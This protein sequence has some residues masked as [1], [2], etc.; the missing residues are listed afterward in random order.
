[1]NIAKLKVP[2]YEDSISKSIIHE[3]LLS[4]NFLNQEEGILKLPKTDPLAFIKYKLLNENI[5][6]SFLV[7]DLGAVYK[8]FKLWKTHL[9][10]VVPFYAVKSNPDKM[11]IKLMIELGM[12]FDCAS[13]KEI[14]TILKHNIST[15]RIIY[16][17][18]CKQ[19][20]HLKYAKEVNVRKMTFDNIDELIKIYIHYPNAELFLRILPLDCHSKVPFSSKF[21]AE[22]E[23]CRQLL[24][25]AKDFNLNVVGLSFHVGSDCLD[26]EGYKETIRRARIIYDQAKSVGFNLSI[27]DIGG[28]FPGIKNVEQFIKI[29]KVVNLSLNDYFKDANL[30][31]IAEPGRF[32]AASFYTLATTVI[33]KRVCYNDSEEKSIMYYLN[34]GVFKSFSEG[35]FIPEILYEPKL[36]FRNG[37]YLPEITEQ[38][39]QFCT[40][41]GPAL[42]AKDKINTDSNL[43]LPELELN[44][45]L[46]F[47]NMGAYST[48]FNMEFNGFEQPLKFY[49]NTEADEL[50]RLLF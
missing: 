3:A 4:P 21:G 9:P 35:A 19:L 7:G 5:Q 10:D 28:G 29:A 46:Y 2:K 39:L 13:K 25:S 42:G 34:D 27:L 50:L 41:W 14:Q 37:L 26:P 22:L 12:S 23:A 16:A 40:L 49:V 18:P 17:N 1:M 15:N 24:Q 47:E 30:T 33:G 32:F 31:F 20:N 48:C 36:L 38:N 8:M 11:L 6:D 44:D 43:R 45:W